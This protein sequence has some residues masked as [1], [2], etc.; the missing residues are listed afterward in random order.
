MDVKVK[1]K[2]EKQVRRDQ[3]LVAVRKP[4]FPHG[5]E[6]ISLNKIPKESQLGVGTL[7]YYC[8]SGRGTC[9]FVRHYTQTPPE[10]SP[11]LGAP[12]MDGSSSKG[13]RSPLSRMRPIWKF[14]NIV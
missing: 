11:I 2:F 6:K 7:Y 10:I 12:S 1:R 9:S 5:V 13:L 4:L 3:L 8:P 14:M